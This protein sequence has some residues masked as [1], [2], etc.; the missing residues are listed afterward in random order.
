MICQEDLLAR[1][2]FGTP[3]GGLWDRLGGQWLLMD[4]DGTKQAADQ[5]ALPAT[6]D[7]PPAF[8]RLDDVCAAGYTGRKRGQV[9]RSR[10]TVSQAHSYQWRGSFG[11]RGNGQYRVERRQGLCSIGRYLTAHQ[12]PQASAFVRLDGQYG[13]GAG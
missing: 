6:P 1:S 3:P 8:R 10:P 9:V 11:N 7:L 2:P 5:R 13:L 12:L 4:V